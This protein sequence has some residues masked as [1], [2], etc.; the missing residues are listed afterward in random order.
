MKL[1]DW[2]FSNNIKKNDFADKIGVNF[3]TVKAWIRHRAHPSPRLMV[4]I[5]EATDYQVLPNDFYKELDS[6][7]E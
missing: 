5:M 7:D 3:H 2:L 1:K 4:K 6:H